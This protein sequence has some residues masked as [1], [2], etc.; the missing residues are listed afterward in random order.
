[1]C[2]SRDSRPDAAITSVPEGT[3]CRRAHKDNNAAERSLRGLAIARKLSFGSFSELG[4]RL[5]G[6]VCSVCATL[7]L[8]GIQPWLWMQAYPQACEDRGGPPPQAER[9]LPWGMPA[10]RLQALRAPG[11]RA[12]P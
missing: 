6:V 4:A 10:E 9:W 7:Q 8:G 3:Y 11:G 2:P 5:L 1:M 12:P